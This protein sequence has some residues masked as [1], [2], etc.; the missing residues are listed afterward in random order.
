VVSFAERFVRVLESVAVDPTVAVGDAA[1]LAE[2]ESAVLLDGWQVAGASVDGEATLVSLFESAVATYPDAVAVRCGDDSVTYAEL[3][4]RVRQF[5]RWL[6]D[7]GVGPD[8]VVA[9]VL[10]RTTD[11]VVAVLAV[12]E[13]GGAYLPIDPAYPAER[14]AYTLADAAPVCVLSWSGRPESVRVQLPVLEVDRFDGGSGAPIAVDERAGAVRPAN[15]AYVIYTSG[16]T[17]RPKGVQV[18]HGNVVEL[19][20]NTGP[21]FGFDETD[22][23]TLFHSYAFD[24][25]VWEL[26]GA[27]AFGGTV[28]VVDYVT[29]RSPDAFRELV[30]REKVTVLNQT[31][32]AFYQFAEADRVAS[33]AG[34]LALRWIVFGG[35]ALDPGRLAGWFDRHGAQSPRLVNMYGIT[36]T[37]VHVSYLE[38][39][40]ESARPG[41]ASVIGRGLG[42]LRVYVLDDRLRP[43]PVGVPGQMYVS[44]GQ[45]S[46][47]YLGQAALTSGRFVADPFAAPGVRMYRTGDLARWNRDGQL[48][49]AGR[50]DMQVQLRGFRIE[51]G[52]VEAALLRCAG[53]AHA[54]AVVRRD[55]RLGDRLVGYVVPEAGAVVEPQVVTEQVGRFLT[56]YMVPDAVVVLEALP[57]TVNGK[58]DQRALP[59]PE[60]GGVRE[61]RAPTTPVEEIVAEVFGDVLGVE[62][63]GLDDDFFALGGNSLIATRVAA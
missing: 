35:E 52:E 17:G 59:A 43:V 24:F 6:I 42:G 27:L 55:E 38:V 32:S 14:I 11:L 16:S 46:R 44:G 12:L 58:L 15:L 20:A 23:W 22:V 61:F 31:P 50:S 40:A 10:P 19:L 57:L 47:G 34:P 36:E 41:A 48:E 56:G 37:T 60:F 53:V 39:G 51:L 54:V 18:A 28:V 45:L 9:V 63:V 1:W 5:A 25:S 3:A 49:Y 26:W 8:A 21:R 30:A 2:G 4:V 7:A 13:A 29:S 33:S 62:R